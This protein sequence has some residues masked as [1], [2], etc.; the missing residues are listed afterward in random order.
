[1]LEHPKGLL[2]CF[3][4]EMWERFSYYGMRALLI[5][6]LTK[7]F[8]FTDE[9]SYA[10]YGAYT[11]LAWGLPVIGG[12]IADRYLGSRKAVTMGAILLVCGHLLLTVEGPSAI[13]TAVA[14]GTGVGRNEP[15]LN[16]FFLSLALIVTGVGFLKTNISTVVGALYAH[17]DPR[18][19]AGFTI[20]YLGI[21]VGAAIAPLICG[22]LGST[23]GW[24]YGFGM[25]GIGMLSGLLLFL[26]GQRFLEGHAEP[27]NYN[28]LRQRVFLG[29]TLEGLN[30]LGAAAMVLVVWQLI[31]HYVHVGAALGGFGIVLAAGILYFSFARC[32]PVERDRMLVVAALLVFSILFWSLYEQI[33]SS[34]NLFADRLVD[35]QIFGIEMQAAQLQSLPGVFIILLAPLFT[36]LWTAMRSR[37]L[38]PNIPVKFAIGLTAIGTAFAMPVIGTAMEGAGHKIGLIWFAAVFIL[39]VCGELCIAPIAMNM[40]TRLCPKRVVGLMMGTYFLSLSVGSF[41]A[42]RFANLT[43]LQGGVGVLDIDAAMSQYT[44]SFKVFTAVGISAGALLYLLSPLLYSR[45]HEPSDQHGVSWIARLYGVWRT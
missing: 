26:W 23:Y 3:G 25:A 8:L 32:T 18:R 28:L 16:L 44:S 20:F 7:H 27:P 31:Q 24:T 41:V 12:L 37:N 38:N 29:L 17:D 10:I 13:E 6:Y 30:C 2:I 15:Y 4:T 36:V 34:L 1:M 9:E 42:A 39:M 21:N 14:G 35:R 11:S 5:F 45:M 19:D 40:I 22:W 33:G 43:S